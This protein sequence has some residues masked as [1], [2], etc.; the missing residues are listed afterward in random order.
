M[1]ALLEGYGFK[2]IELKKDL[3]GKDRMV[4]GVK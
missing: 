4:K 3:F 2:N 1:L